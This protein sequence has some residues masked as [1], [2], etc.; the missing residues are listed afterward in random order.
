LWGSLITVA[1]LYSVFVDGDW[2]QRPFFSLDYWVPAIGRVVILFSIAN[3]FPGW[4]ALL[5][6][7]VVAMIIATFDVWI[8][9]RLWR[10]LLR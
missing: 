3:S 10:L 5:A 6:A 2:K 7:V 4:W 9:P 1:I 8:V